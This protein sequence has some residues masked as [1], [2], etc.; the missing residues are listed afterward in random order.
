MVR[1]V[2]IGHR[3]G[4]VVRRLAGDDA[5]ARADWLA[6]LRLAPDGAAADAARANLE[7]LDVKTD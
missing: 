4:L 7:R 5:G 1:V 3:H 6:I 2:H